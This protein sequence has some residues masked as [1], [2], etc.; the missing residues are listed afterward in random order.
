VSPN[1]KPQS[2]NW[3]LES[4][5]ASAGDGTVYREASYI[6]INEKFPLCC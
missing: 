2:G 5:P 1:L 4:Q 3:R 6:T